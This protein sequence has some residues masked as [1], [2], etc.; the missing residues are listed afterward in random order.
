MKLRT[1]KKNQSNQ[2]LCMFK[3]NKV[4][5]FLTRLRANKKENTNYKYHN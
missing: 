2:R 4:V 1:E 5:T 3:F